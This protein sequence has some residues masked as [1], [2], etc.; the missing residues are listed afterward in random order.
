MPATVAK[1]SSWL[2]STPLRLASCQQA[3]LAML[4]ELQTFG[5]HGL[6]FGGK[7]ELQGALEV[8]SGQGQTQDPKLKANACN[9]IQRLHSQ[10][11]PAFETKSARVGTQCETTITLIKPELQDRNRCLGFFD[12]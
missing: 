12:L 5:S 3:Q 1:E 9:T 7:V 6:D 11:I 8:S 4:W 2:I 10:E